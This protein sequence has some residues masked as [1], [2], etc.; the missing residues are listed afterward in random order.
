MNEVKKCTENMKEGDILFMVQRL[1]SAII[2]TN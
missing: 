1:S 2:K